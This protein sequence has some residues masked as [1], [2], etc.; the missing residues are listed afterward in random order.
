MKR[1]TLAQEALRPQTGPGTFEEGGHMKFVVAALVWF[2][3]GTLLARE[4]IPS[5]CADT[6]CTDA[7]LK[8]D[9]EFQKLQT[10]PDFSNL[11]QV[12][13][14]KCFMM[15]FATPEEDTQYGVTMITNQNGQPYFSGLFSF[16]SPTDPYATMTFDEIV[17]SL[18]ISGSKPKEVTFENN[19]AHVQFLTSGSEINYWFRQ[20][21]KTQ[22]LYLISRWNF[23]NSYQ[24]LQV[25]CRMQAH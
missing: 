21:P 19:A 11:P 16:A 12:Y 20:D 10:A 7:M 6:E 9:S 3:S 5:L 22:E 17:H 1:K 24:L 15:G 25:F 4:D 14:G 23:T 2:F 13:H 18:E 8:I